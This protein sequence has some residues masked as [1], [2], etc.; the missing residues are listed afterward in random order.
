[1]IYAL[2]GGFHLFRSSI[3]K[4]QKISDSLKQMGV[5]AIAPCH[6]TGDKPC[7]WCR[8][9]NVVL[10]CKKLNNLLQASSY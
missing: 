3:K 4:I 10:K 2:F 1:M 8:F 9:K 5:K 7:E 6:C